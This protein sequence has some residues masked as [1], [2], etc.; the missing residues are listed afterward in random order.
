MTTTTV[1][2]G[3]KEKVYSHS[4]LT[5]FDEWCERAFFHKY[6]E[7]RPEPS[8]LPAVVGK[9]FHDAM[10]KLLSEGYSPEEAVFFSIYEHGG[11]PEGEKEVYLISMVNRT[12]NRIL[13]FA[14]EY[15]DVLS[16]LHLV[17]DIGNGRK[18]QGYLDLVIDNPAYDVVTINDFKTTW[19]PFS[20]EGS[21]QL[22][23][24][25]WMFEKMRGGFVASTF[26]GK[27]IFPRFDE[28]MDSEI[29]FT[30]ESMDEAYEWVV[31]VIE[32]IDSRDPSNIEDWAMTANRKNCEHCAF[33][34][35]CSGGF[36]NGL[37]GDGIPKDE[38]EA[39]HIGE[40]ILMQ[41]LA[42]KRMKEGLKGFVKT[43]GAVPV[44]G[45]RWEFVQSE[46]TPT[47]PIKVLQQYAEDNGFDP[48]TVLTTE[49]KAV[50][51]WI[52]EDSTGYLKAQATWSNPKNS[53]KFVEDEKPEK[54]KR[55]KRSKKGEGKVDE[56]E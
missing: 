27:L 33:S 51:K 21:R 39:A 16:E 36:L 48:E 41:E 13:Q 49:K 55:S 22:K 14:D 30:R 31:S 42:I 1:V 37:P 35:L 8:G 15:S 6:I 38:D 34:T 7:G 26:K 10:N 12:Y 47:V 19:Q 45:G 20:A 53:F 54:P 44:R 4:R 5:L 25:A 24:Y 3:T 40:F 17:V 18:I 9:I 56:Q 2:V 32:E 11:L 43:K 23:L 46:P 29:E 28:S 52:D 50:K